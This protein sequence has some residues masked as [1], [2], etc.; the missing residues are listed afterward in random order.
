[1]RNYPIAGMI[2]DDYVN[3]YVSKETEIVIIVFKEIC[4][5]LEQKYEYSYTIPMI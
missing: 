1:M 4:Y 5:F 2:N 3:A